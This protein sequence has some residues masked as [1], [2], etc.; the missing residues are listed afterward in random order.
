MAA[1]EAVTNQSESWE[2]HARVV[3]EELNEKQRRWVAGMMSEMLGWGGTKRVAELT[4]LDPKTIRQGRIDL[5]NNL[6][7]FPS[8][9]IRREGG[10]RP[11]L[12]TR[13]SLRSLAD[14][15]GRA[16]RTSIA[17]LLRPLGYSLQANV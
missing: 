10:G 16:S 7:G 9:R 17:Q 8:E 4:G 3:F 1:I 11:P 14:R 12:Y 2:V 13:S 5:Q 6:D 15:F